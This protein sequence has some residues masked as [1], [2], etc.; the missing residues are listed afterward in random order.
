MNDINT[1]IDNFSEYIGDYQ[2]HK[3]LDLIIH[4]GKIKYRTNRDE[5]QQIKNLYRLMDDTPDN[6]INNKQTIHNKKLV[7]KEK[8]KKPYGMTSHFFPEV[9]QNFILENEK[10][11]LVYSF[12]IDKRQIYIYISLFSDDDFYDL[13][14][15][16][17]CVEKMI[18]WLYICNKYSINGSN[19]VSERLDIYLYPTEYMKALPNIS[20]DVLCPFHVNSGFSTSC[21][22]ENEIVIYRKEEW[23]KVFVHETFHSFCFDIR[24]INNMEE[25]IFELFTLSKS[26]IPKLLIGETYAEVWA[27]IINIVFNCYEKTDNYKDFELCFNFSLEIEKM[28]GIIQANKIL[29]HFNLRYEDI[30]FRI[31][32]KKQL[33]LGY[34]EKTNVFCYYIL[35]AIL[36]FDSYK[37]LH[38]CCKNNTRWIKFNNNPIISREFLNLITKSYNKEEIIKQFNYF[39]RNTYYTDGDTFLKMTII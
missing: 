14:Q 34:K 39:Y 13:E 32:K 22:R 6:Y 31:P 8:I 24:N 36:M 3:Y 1:D 18:R 23:F 28:F 35:S 16:D 2:I 4:S 21:A 7:E 9:I 11:Q 20:M 37:F 5:R 17:K 10:K 38:W 33:P 30:L 27:R 26:N 29:K 15:Y 25:R 19:K 12:N